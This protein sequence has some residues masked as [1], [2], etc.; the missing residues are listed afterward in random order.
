VWTALLSAW[1]PPV[2]E[3]DTE[4]EKRHHEALEAAAHD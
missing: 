1:Y 2:Q 4:D 3:G